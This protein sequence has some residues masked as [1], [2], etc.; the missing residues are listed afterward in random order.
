MF[1]LLETFH[2][3]LLEFLDAYVLRR[4]LSLPSASSTS[5]LKSIMFIIWS[6]L[7]KKIDYLTF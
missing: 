3:F 2:V 5:I 6:E 4:L 1:L 7:A